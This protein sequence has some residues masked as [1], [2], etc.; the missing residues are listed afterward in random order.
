MFFSTTNS[1]YLITIRYLLSVECLDVTAFDQ[2]LILFC[3]FAKASLAIVGYCLITVNKTFCLRA[4]FITLLTAYKFHCLSYIQR[5]HLIHS[6]PIYHSYKIIYINDSTI[7]YYTRVKYVKEKII[8]TFENS[9]Q[10]TQN[11]LSF[12]NR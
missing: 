5:Y 7:L 11:V 3:M 4:T 2:H 12:R 9:C 1:Y 8:C 6:F 10:I